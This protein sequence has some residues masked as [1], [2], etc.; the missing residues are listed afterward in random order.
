MAK[1]RLVRALVPSHLHVQGPRLLAMA[2]QPAH[3][4]RTRDHG[5]RMDDR[6]RS[7]WRDARSPSTSRLGRAASIIV[8]PI[9]FLS[10]F[11][12]PS[13][14]SLALPYGVCSHRV[15]VQ[16]RVLLFLHL[17]THSTTIHH[18]HHLWKGEVVS[19][20]THY[21]HMRCKSFLRINL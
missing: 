8:S 1:P 21:S 9:F 3:S 17:G 13:G 14:P 18:T 7:A 16:Q 15:L 5:S 12:Q 20:F 11:G 4:L 19:V 6:R 2:R 10:C